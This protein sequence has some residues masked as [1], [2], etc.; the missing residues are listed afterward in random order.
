MKTPKIFLNLEEAAKMMELSV[1]EVKDFIAN[2]DLRAYGTKQEKLKTCE[3]TNLIGEI[4]AKSSMETENAIMLQ[5]IHILTDDVTNRVIKMAIAKHGE[6]SVYWNEK[7]GCYQAAFYITMPDGTKKRKI[8]SGHSEVE[9]ISKMH[10]VKS[11]ANGTASI[12][13]LAVLAATYAGPEDKRTV[14]EVF[15]EFMESK[16]DC[17]QNTIKS[18]YY[19]GQDIVKY[20]GNRY[21]HTIT[22]KDIEEFLKKKAS[23][24]KNGKFSESTFVIRRKTLAGM[25]KLADKYH[26]IVK[27]TNPMQDVNITMPAGEKT[28]RDAKFLEPKQVAMVLNCLSDNPRYKAIVQVLVSTGLRIAELTALKWDDINIDTRNVPEDEKLHTLNI[29]RAM[30]LNPDYIAN[31]PKH[32][33][34]IIGTTKSTASYRTIPL[35]Q[36]T[37]DIF[38]AWK[39]TVQANET[40]ME[41]II[42]NK[43]QDLI[44][45]NE[46]GQMM[47]YQ[48]LRHHFGEYLDAVYKRSVQGTKSKKGSKGNKN[49]FPF[50]VTF[51]M[52]RHTYGSLLLEQG[53]DLA[54]VSRYL[55]HASIKITLDIY[56]TITDKLKIK[57]LPKIGNILSMCN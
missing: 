31:D 10:G 30:K 4:P 14:E 17:A 37:L 5:Y 47:N 24:K 57:T 12:S 6:G 7:R 13:D 38:N 16:K 53:V 50:K 52:F 2:G 28:D 45:T 42:A 29:H 48:T 55:G 18:Y 20:M 23:E 44:F 46:Q 41:K 22:V 54:V 51:H 39:A 11:A 19:A 33:R 21:I 40:L 25:F 36:E 3:V 26:Y 43:T 1:D 34:Y 35:T 27:G 56:T 15:N 9:A 32:P 8:V 49:K